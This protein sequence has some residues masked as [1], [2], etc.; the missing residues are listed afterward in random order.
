MSL[1][2]ADPYVNF[3]QTGWKSKPA[4]AL[5]EGAQAK[6]LPPLPMPGGAPVSSFIL[7]HPCLD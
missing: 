2:S 3:E 7:F 4:A 1:S 6:S 5:A